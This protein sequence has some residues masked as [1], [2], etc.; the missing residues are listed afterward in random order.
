[1]T[2]DTGSLQAHFA[3][4]LVGGAAAVVL[5]AAAAS[6]CLAYLDLARRQDE[7]L[8]AAARS[9]RPAAEPQLDF[10]E[11]DGVVVRAVREPRERGAVPRLAE[12]MALRLPAVRQ[13][14]IPVVAAAAAGAAAMLAI[15]WLAW[16]LARRWVARSLARFEQRAEATPAP[17]ELRPTLERLEALQREQREG[18]DAQR[19]FLADAAH[20]LRTPLAVLRAEVQDALG[21]R[22]DP[23]ARLEGMLHTVD[24]ATTVANHLL[25]LSRVA[26]LGRDGELGAVAIAACVRDAIIELSPLISA[27]R[28]EFSLDG[29]GFDA[30]GDAVML[31]ELVRNL[32]GNAIHHSPAG[33]RGGVVL[34]TAPC[35]E[36]IVWDEGPGVDD[37]LK[38]RL[39]TPFGAGRGGV[40]LGLSICQQVAAAMGAQVHLYNR[41]ED[42]RVCGVDAVVRWAAP[43][44]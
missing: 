11:A 6:A 36:V 16:L 39:F 26:Q 30:A 29:E 37:A 8:L 44:P 20:Q 32:L 35:K 19:R 40:G 24:R 23:R 17:A 43:A 15:A 25:S 10:A 41:V 7:R 3:R 22:G 21:G 33:A 42:G 2:P 14:L 1:V 13:V 27:K 38:P 18:V 4:W 34:R 28:L 5:T 31:G 9:E 12:P